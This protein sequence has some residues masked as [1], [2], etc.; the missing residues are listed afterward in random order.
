MFEK[1]ALNVTY[2]LTLCCGSA[3]HLDADPDPAF[4][5]DAG[6]DPESDPVWG[7]AARFSV[8]K[9]SKRNQSENRFASKQ[10]GDIS[11]VL[12]RS[13]TAKI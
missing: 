12:H 8:P 2:T 5:F 13:E 3:Y 10:K 7:G 9:R 1:V 6:L 11:L 4:Y